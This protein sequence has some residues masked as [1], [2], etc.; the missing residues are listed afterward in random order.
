MGLRLSS[1]PIHPGKEPLEDRS[2]RGQQTGGTHSW[3]KG[4]LGPFPPEGLS[5]GV[6][7]AHDCRTL[8]R[9]AGWVRRGLHSIGG[10]LGRG[11]EEEE[12]EGLLFGTV[13]KVPLELG[14]RGG[15]AGDLGFFPGSQASFH[16][17]RPSGCGEVPERH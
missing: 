6:P 5:M 8:T 9:K 4:A 3:P 16:V 12:G 14:G 13:C 15:T 17:K 1:H 11:R 10:G 7:R 2:G